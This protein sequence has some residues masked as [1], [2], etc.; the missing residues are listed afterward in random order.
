MMLY[1]YGWW[2]LWPNLGSAADLTENVRGNSMSVYQ[3]PCYPAGYVSD[4]TH[5]SRSD[6]ISISD[7]AILTAFHSERTLRFL[8]SC[9]YVTL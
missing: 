1:V 4:K 8:F 3:L 9:F 6:L 7:T 5:H 2:T